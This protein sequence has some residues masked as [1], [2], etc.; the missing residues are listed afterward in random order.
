M[1][2][3]HDQ[4]SEEYHDGYLAFRPGLPKPSCPYGDGHAR[5]EWERGWTDACAQY[6]A[7]GREEGS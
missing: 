5:S 1:T 4:Q 2:D 6:L 7:E 3:E